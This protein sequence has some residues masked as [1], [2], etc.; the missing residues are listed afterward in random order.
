M[1]GIRLDRF[2]HQ[3]E[4]VGAFDLARN[5]VI[6]VWPHGVGFG[7]VTQA[8]NAVSRMVKHHEDRALAVFR[9]REQCEVIGA[10]IEHEEKV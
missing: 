8:I 1:F 9:P 10:E 4:F 6:G 3:I 5:A 7:E 2:D